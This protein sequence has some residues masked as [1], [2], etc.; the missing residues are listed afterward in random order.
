MHP[1]IGCFEGIARRTR[2]LSTVIAVTGVF[3]I[4]AVVPVA[5]HEKPN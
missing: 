1:T 5:A 3:T 2:K 4:S